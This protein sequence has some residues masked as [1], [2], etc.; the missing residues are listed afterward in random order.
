[1]LFV[2]SGFEHSVANMYFIPLGKFLGANI[3]W[4]QIWMANLIPVTIG[5]IIGGAILIPGVYWYVYKKSEEKQ[6]GFK[7][8]DIKEFKFTKKD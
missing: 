3:T 8:S 5:N 1:M 4:S 2:L 7:N 6:V